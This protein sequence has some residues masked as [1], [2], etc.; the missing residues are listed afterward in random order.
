MNFIKKPTHSLSKSSIYLTIAFF[1][2]ILIACGQKTQ[3]VDKGKERLDK[4]CDTF[5]ELFTEN[6]TKAALRLI[7]Q[8]TVISHSTIDTLQLT[9]DSQMNNL[10]RVYGKMLSYEFITEKKIKDFYA[11]RF[12]VVK[13]DVYYLKFDF[14]LYKSTNGWTITYFKY[15]EELNELLN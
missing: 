9:I 6:K 7:K 5:M 10:T 2:L 8:N 11:K 4:V 1:T 14:T 15:N 12:Y 3:S 13:F